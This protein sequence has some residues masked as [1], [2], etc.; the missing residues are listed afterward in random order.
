MSL[1]IKGM[2]MPKS[3]RYCAIKELHNDDGQESVCQ[4]ICGKSV[5]EYIYCVDKRHPDCPLVEVPTPHGDLID[6]NRIMYELG[7]S[8]MSRSNRE[9]CIRVL[10]A[11]SLTPIIIEAEG[12]K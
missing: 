7:E 11:K 9:F 8:T 10:T 6:K 5:E 4:L 12:V 2:D 1:I 3:C